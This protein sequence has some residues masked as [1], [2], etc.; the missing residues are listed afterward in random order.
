MRRI[1]RRL[2]QLNDEISALRRDEQLAEEE[3]IFHQHLNDDAARDAAV[4]DSPLDRADARET[5]SDVAR[6]ELHIA[7]LRRSREKLESQRDRLVRKLR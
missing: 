7:K 5:A 4:S 6:F 1:E 2:F 3:L